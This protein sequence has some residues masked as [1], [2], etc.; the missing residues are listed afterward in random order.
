ML[1][2][3]L[4]E[5]LFILVKTWLDFGFHVVQGQKACSLAVGYTPGCTRFGEPS[6]WGMAMQSLFD[7]QYS[8][9]FI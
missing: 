2:C 1:G 4:A 7:T 6:D 8:T 5:T 3:L 9:L